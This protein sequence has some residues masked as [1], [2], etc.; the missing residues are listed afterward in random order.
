M[1]VGVAEFLHTT[2]DK[3]TMAMFESRFVP[4]EATLLA[5]TRSPAKAEKAPSRRAFLR[6]ILATFAGAQLDPLIRAMLHDKTLIAEAAELSGAAIT[7]DLH[8]HANS[9]RGRTLAEFDSEIPDNMRGGGLDAGVFAVR[10][11]HGTLRR[12]PTGHY[13]ESRKPAVGVLFQSS[14]DQLDKVLKAIK[15]GKIGLAK[16]PTEVVEAKKNRQPCAVLA[17]EGSDPLE[18][19]LSRVNF[20]YDLGVRVLQLMHYRINEVGDIMTEAPHH[21]GL[22]TFGQDVVKEM[23]KLG[24]VIDVA[25]A[26]PETVGGVLGASRHPVICSHTGAYA[27][28]TNS[29]HLEDKDMTAISKKGG[30]IG[31]WPLLRRR[32]NFQTYIRELDYVKNLVGADHVGIG[33]DLF[34]IASE[35]AIPTHKEFAL[36]PAALLS[37]GYRETDVEKIV[38]GNFM[39]VFREVA[40]GTG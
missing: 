11:D 21:K 33:T 20:F 37:R 24:M 38:G 7:V 10:G 35:T 13:T 19:D 6:A 28:R 25:H 2:R 29:R 18:G 27:L 23:N 3:P 16:S 31:V 32:D 8:C 40:R 36:V 14:Q 22:T 17:I 26:S 30:V 9:S 39:R 5:G 1:I 34:G 15:A 12:S 4:L